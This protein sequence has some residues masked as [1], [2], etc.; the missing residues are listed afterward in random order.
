MLGALSHVTLFDLEWATLN[1]KE[2]VILRE[3][4]WCHLRERHFQLQ[5]TS[6]DR[7]SLGCV[8]FRGIGKPKYRKR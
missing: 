1:K 8:E 4:L 5:M 7:K 2:Q 6:G 3:E